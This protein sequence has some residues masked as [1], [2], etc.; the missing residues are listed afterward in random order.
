MWIGFSCY[1]PPGFH[2]IPDKKKE[3]NLP[4]VGYFHCSH[5]G[6]TWKKTSAIASVNIKFHSTLQSDMLL[7]FIIWVVRLLF[8]AGFGYLINLI[9]LFIHKGVSKIINDI[10]YIF[11]YCFLIPLRE[12]S[13]LPIW[14]VYVTIDIFVSFCL[15]TFNTGSHFMCSSNKSVELW[16]DFCGQKVFQV[17]E[18]FTPHWTA[19]VLTIHPPMKCIWV[20][21][22]VF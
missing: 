2:C 12:K 21:W 14:S 6:I 16:F 7:I 17:L 22:Q 18:A 19:E 20:N 1:C 5:I 8:H 4:H 13:K 11:P 15:R 10:G 3:I 9:N